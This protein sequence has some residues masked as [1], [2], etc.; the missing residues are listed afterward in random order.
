MIQLTLL[1]QV[2]FV[3]SGDENPSELA[4][5]AQK[6]PITLARRTQIFNAVYRE[7]VASTTSIE[8]EWQLWIRD[9][10]RRRLSCALWARL[11]PDLEIS[12]H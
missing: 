5:A 3:Y 10:E 1:N 2:G 4:E 12:E 7:N 8:G 6:L 9:E 11:S